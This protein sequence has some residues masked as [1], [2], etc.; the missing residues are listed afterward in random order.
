MSEIVLVRHGQANSHATNEADYDRLSPLGHEQSRWLGAWLREHELPFDRCL[1]GTLRRHRETADGLGETHVERDPRLNELDYFQL[2]RALHDVHG[3]PVPDP[4]GFAQH[5]PQVM[6]AWHAAEIEGAET[7]ESFESRVRDALA[8]I[9]EM[10]GRSLVVT[11]GGVIAMAMRLVLDLDATRFARMLL[12]IR[13]SSI[14]RLQMLDGVMIVAAFN[15]TPHLDP[16]HRADA[17]THS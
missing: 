2:G 9:S 4:G 16:H 6:R 7:F 11:S 12:P 1:S 14:H 10:G 5:A 17:R 3:V 13:N 8:D 15:A